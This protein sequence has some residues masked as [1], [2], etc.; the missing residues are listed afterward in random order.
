MTENKALLIMPTSIR[1]TLYEHQRLEFMAQK[2][3]LKKSEFIRV[4]VFSKEVERAFELLITRREERKEMA[5]VLA[6]I[7]ASRIASNLNQL[8]KAANTG[9]LELS[10]TVIAQLNEAY[11]TVMRM[12]RMLI[13]F[14]GVKI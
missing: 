8:A 4:A 1:F 5:R 9:C 10:P 3:G 12:N 7:G 11:D 13:T 14:Q 6:A 2:L